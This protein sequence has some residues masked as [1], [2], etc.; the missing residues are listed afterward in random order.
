MGRG[1][2]IDLKASAEASDSIAK[3]KG[4][5]KGIIQPFNYDRVQLLDG[6]LKDQFEEVK[7]SGKAG[8]KSTGYCAGIR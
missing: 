7:E 6:R 1:L 4:D 2:G 5:P 3:V 8:I